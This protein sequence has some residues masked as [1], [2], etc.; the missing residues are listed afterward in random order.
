MTLEVDISLFGQVFQGWLMGIFMLSH[1]CFNV[2]RGESLSWSWYVS[3]SVGHSVT[4]LVTQSL[5]HIHF[6]R[7]VFFKSLWTC[8]VSYDLLWSP[9]VP[10]SPLWSHIWPNMVLEAPV[11]S[12]WSCMVSY[13]P[14][15][16]NF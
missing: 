14:L 11:W 7:S 13:G 9:K 15:W 10:Y 6:S 8:M 2:I 12:L 3:H 4:R 16:S 5:G 1:W